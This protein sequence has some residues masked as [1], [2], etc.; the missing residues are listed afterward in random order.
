MKNIFGGLT[1][2]VAV[3]FCSSLMTIPPAA[4]AEAESTLVVEN[5]WSPQMPPGIKVMAGYL[6]A[7]NVS[8]DP[9]T[10][11]GLSSPAYQSVEMHRSVI[12]DGMAN[13]VEVKELLVRPGERIEF[14][15]GG[16]HLMLINRIAATTSAKALPI[17]LHLDNGDLTNFVLEIVPRH[18]QP[19]EVGDAYDHSAH[20]HH[21]R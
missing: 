20:M 11:T 21:G 8:A 1:I 14:S 6:S 17:R 13:M 4:S 10:I 19:L 9:I 15:P 16:L 3:L 5:A 12:E 2:L 7:V 18:A